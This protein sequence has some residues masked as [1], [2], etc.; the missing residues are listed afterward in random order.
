MFGEVPVPGA[1]V[2]ASKGDRKVV[3]VTDELGTSTLGALEDGTWSIRVEMATFAVLTRDV[4]VAPATPASA[5]ALTLKPLQEIVS[6]VP[7][8]QPRPSATP[9][10][11]APSA[12]P[13]PTVAASRPA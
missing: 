8:G 4:D 10:A 9:T 6:T 3:T 2:T 11:M 1:T 7:S 13:R 12:A 5:W